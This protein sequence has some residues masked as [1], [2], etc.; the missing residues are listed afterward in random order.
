MTPN[1]GLSAVSATRRSLHKLRSAHTARHSPTARAA[2]TEP[3]QTRSKE[4][5]QHPGPPSAG[6]CSV[7]SV[8]QRSQ[9]CGP[10][11]APRRARGGRGEQSPA[12]AFRAPGASAS[13]RGSAPL[14]S[15]LR[16]PSLSP[17]SVFPGRIFSA[18]PWETLLYYYYH[19]FIP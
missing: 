12:N 6:G 9:L 10:G 5:L 16:F 15:Q 18:T 14:S 3:R 17:L 19:Y 2:V 11:G 7:L 1:A 8:P 13:P 4:P